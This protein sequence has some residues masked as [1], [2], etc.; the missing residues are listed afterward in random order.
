MALIQN[1]FFYLSCLLFTLGPLL[2]LTIFS[3]SV[4]LFDI[5][6]TIYIISYIF[7]NKPIISKNLVL[8]IIWT[9]LSHFINIFHFGF[10]TGSFFYLLKLFNL[11]L[12]TYAQFK[13]NQKQKN[14]FVLVVLANLIFGFF[15]YLIWPDLYNF[16]FLGWDPH[17]YRLVST[18]L[19]PTFT[20]LIYLLLIIYLFIK[21]Y[22]KI[23]IFFTY[24]GLSLTYSR[25]TFL[26]L[27]LI[28]FVYSLK[29]TKNF[30][31]FLKVLLLVALT[32]FLLPKPIGESTNLT[33]TSTIKAKLINYQQALQTIKLNPVIGQGY[34]NLP[35]L[36]SGQTSTPDHSLSGFD[37]SLLTITATTGI[38]G[39]ILYI[40]LLSSSLKTFAYAQKYALIAILIHSLFS[41]SLLYSWAIFSFFVLFSDKSNSRILS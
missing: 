27:V 5:S 41:N 24:T 15:Q 22:P 28:S 19:D 2:K 8:F 31:F 13:L 21:K 18:F 12:L 36:L 37:S 16:K 17:Q 30:Y 26:A 35:L 40:N 6:I 9:I 20:G 29:I 38:L 10:N 33:R 4:P 11:C 1:I 32:I 14:I 25:S 7:T 23:L 39:L 3:S 34:N